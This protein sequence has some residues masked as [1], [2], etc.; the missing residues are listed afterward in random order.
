MKTYY[1]QQ[2]D[3]H[4]NGIR[5]YMDVIDEDG[6]FEVEVTTG[7]A[8]GYE[9]DEGNPEIWTSVCCSIPNWNGEPSFD[10]RGTIANEKQLKSEL[11]SFYD[12]P[13]KNIR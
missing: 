5:R 7:M 4:R 1:V 10:I 6:G 9:D 12:V 11:A 8:D 13:D 3:Q 2:P